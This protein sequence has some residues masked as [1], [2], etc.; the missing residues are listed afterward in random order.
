[1]ELHLIFQSSNKIESFFKYKDR[2]P[3]RVTGGVV[4]KYTCQECH[5]TYVGETVRHLYTRISEHKGVSARTGL[6]LSNPKSNIYNH[7]LNTGHAISENSFEIVILDNSSNLKLLES[8]VISEIKPSLNEK[9]YS[10][11]LGIV[12]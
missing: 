2:V 12:V 9:L 5:L 1:M 8:I 6:P 10:T 11:P 3:P 4:Y 7:F